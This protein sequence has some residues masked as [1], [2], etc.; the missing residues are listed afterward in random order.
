MEPSHLKKGKYNSRFWT[1]QS[2]EKINVYDL[3]LIFYPNKKINFIRKGTWLLYNN[4]YINSNT[5]ERC[6]PVLSESL[7]L[8]G[9]HN[10]LVRSALH[11][12]PIWRDWEPA[13]GWGGFEIKPQCYKEAEIELNQMCWVFASNN[14]KT[15]DLRFITLIYRWGS[16]WGDFCTADSFT[17]CPPLGKSLFLGEARPDHRWRHPRPSSLSRFSFPSIQH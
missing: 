8:L 4:I 5:D 11:P 10:Q 6:D 16:P 2:K 12:F 7:W 9:H 15:S 14:D 13:E 3:I 17:L 1:A